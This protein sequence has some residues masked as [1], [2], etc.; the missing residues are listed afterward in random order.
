MLAE[1]EGM[2]QVSVGPREQYG[3]ERRDRTE[4]RGM[5]SILRGQGLSQCISNQSI[6]SEL[7]AKTRFQS[8]GGS[9]QHSTVDK[10]PG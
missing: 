7:E 9:C 2:P 5:S 1:Q 3:E 6:V 8:S 10:V 4:R